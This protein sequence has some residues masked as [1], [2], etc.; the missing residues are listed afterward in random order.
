MIAWKDV[1]AARIPAAGAAALGPVGGE[2][3]HAELLPQLRERALL[4]AP[5]LL[6]IDRHHHRVHHF[7]HHAGH[8]GDGVP[9][10]QGLAHLPIHTHRDPALVVHLAWLR[11]ARE[12]LVAV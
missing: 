11:Y 1:T 6:A 9:Q 10:G 12:G 3:G 5:A 8:L 2:D 4:A 7:W